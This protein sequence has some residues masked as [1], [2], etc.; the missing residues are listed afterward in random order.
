VARTVNHQLYV[1]RHSVQPKSLRTLVWQHRL[2]EQAGSNQ[3]LGSSACDVCNLWLGRE[4]Q[5]ASLVVT[6]SS[7][8]G[9][10]DLQENPLWP[11]CWKTYSWH[12]CLD[13][14]TGWRLL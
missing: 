7:R 9:I 1:E 12:R 11:T 13:C 10:L 2:A 3:A 6:W 14:S 8:L 5:S 4:G